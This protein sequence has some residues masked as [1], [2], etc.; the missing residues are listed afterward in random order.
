MVIQIYPDYPQLSQATATLIANVVQ[1]KPNA[2]LCLASGNSPEGVF[3][4]LVEMAQAGQIDFSQCTF[5]SLDEWVGISPDNLGSCWYMV[6]E[7]LLKPL[8]I[9]PEQ[10]Y[11]FD[12]LT[13]NPQ[14]ECGR[15]DEAVAALGGLDVILVGIGLNGH[16]AMNEPHTP[17]DLY[18]HMS[19]LHESTK[20]VGQKY[21]QESTELTY[22]LTVGLRYVQETQL[23]ILIANGTKKAAIIKQALQGTITTEVPG[24][25]FQQIPNGH[26]LLDE[27][28]ASGLSELPS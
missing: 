9:R 18:S 2:V 4:S 5:I 27:A 6:N 21:F 17:W 23:P 20:S 7:F 19:E 12:G 25:I 15:I 10:I 11:F 24:S 16:I 28:A 8:N 26:V 1:Q 3:K 22:G 13:A 14:A